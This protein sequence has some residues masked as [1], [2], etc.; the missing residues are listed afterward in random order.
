MTRRTDIAL[1]AVLPL[2]AYSAAGPAV[3]SLATAGV[4]GSATGSA[5]ASVAAGF[6][7]SY[8]VDQGMKYAE[9][10]IQD[11]VQ[12]AIARAAAPLEVG[13]SATW[14]VAE[15]LPVTGKS[16]NVEVARRFGEAIPCK[17]VVFTVADDDDHNIYTTSICRNDQGTWMWALA[18]PSV[19]RWGYL[20]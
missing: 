9:R 15:K 20:Q 4:V 10:R 1:I 17:D 5:L 2:A 14:E 18:E 7:A 3:T 19:H 6:G 13:Q 11:N 12:T 16:G 8:G